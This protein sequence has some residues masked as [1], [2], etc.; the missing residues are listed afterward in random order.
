[1]DQGAQNKKLLKAN[2]QLPPVAFIVIPEYN[3]VSHD[4]YVLWTPKK[5][6][7]LFKIASML[8]KA[9]FELKTGVSSL[10]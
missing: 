6:L 2:Y 9:S 8:S 3:S 4:N 5:F 7:T 1:M 10:I